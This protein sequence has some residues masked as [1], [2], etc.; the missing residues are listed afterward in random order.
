M[1]DSIMPLSDSQVFPPLRHR[2]LMRLPCFGLCPANLDAMRDLECAVAQRLLAWLQSAPSHYTELLRALTD[3]ASP[4]REEAQRLTFA[5]WD[6]TQAFEW[7][8]PKDA[9]TPRDFLW[10]FA[11]L[12]AAGLLK[13]EGL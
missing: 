3:E 9:L 6:E 8:S 13:G 11:C 5:L 1:N 2:A 10:Q 4:L 12:R 7:I